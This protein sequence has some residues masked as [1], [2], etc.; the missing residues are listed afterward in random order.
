LLDDNNS[1]GLDPLLLALSHPPN[2]EIRVFN[3]MRYR[4]LRLLNYMADLGRTQRRMHGKIFTIDQSATIIGGRNIADPY[5]RVTDE[6]FLLI[7]MCWQWAACCQQR[8]HI[9][10]GFGMIRCLIRFK[11]FCTP[12]HRLSNALL[13]RCLT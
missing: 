5:Y 10:S 9:L 8:M 11:V 4:K 7:S 3:P 12:A 6:Y 2:F 1:K 13:I